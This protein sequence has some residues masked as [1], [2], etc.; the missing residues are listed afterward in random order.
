MAGLGHIQGQLYFR[1]GRARLSIFSP[2]PTYL[3][4]WAEETLQ[5]LTTSLLIE[6]RLTTN[7]EEKITYVRRED[8]KRCCRCKPA[9]QRK[10]WILMNLLQTQRWI[11]NRQDQATFIEILDR[12]QQIDHNR[13]TPHDLRARTDIL[14][15][16]LDDRWLGSNKEL[17]SRPKS[18]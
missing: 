16:S 9:A 5:L 11:A 17:M 18:P 7:F 1:A 4:I 8:Q 3:I 15:V 10:P 12:L 14:I 2:E 6:R 13:F